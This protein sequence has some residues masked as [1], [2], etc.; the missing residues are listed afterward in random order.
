MVIKVS[1]EHVKHLIKLYQRGLGFANKD[2]K[3]LI[4]EVYVGDSD[5]RVLLT[6][7]GTREKLRPRR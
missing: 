2:L 4:P 5:D 3:R 7:A 1:R 6:C